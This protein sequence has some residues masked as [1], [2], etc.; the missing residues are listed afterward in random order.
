MSEKQKQTNTLL[1]DNSIYAP[2]RSTGMDFSQK[3]RE[4]FHLEREG[5]GVKIVSDGIVDEDALIQSEAKN[6][7]LVNILRMQ[8]LRYGTVENAVK[9]NEAKQVFAD[10]SK[11]PTSIGEQV[12]Y[13]QQKEKEVNDLAAKLGISKEELL[14]SNLET[15]TKLCQGKETISQATA[16][17]GN[18]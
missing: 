17:G 2:V 18:E 10:V 1:P 11:I 4:H 13:I 15:L 5:N 16:E 12:E 3:N 14:N 9:R 7:G 8:E 6:A